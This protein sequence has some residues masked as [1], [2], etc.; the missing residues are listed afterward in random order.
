VSLPASSALTDLTGRGATVA[1]AG[2]MAVV[3]AIDLGDG[4][5]GPI[6][7]I[8]FV[9]V[10]VAVA[11]AVHRRYL[12]TAAVL[13]PVLLLSTFLAVALVAP[14]AVQ[15]P[16]MAPDI[17]WAGRAIAGVVDRGITLTVGY[18]LA[19]ATIALRVASRPL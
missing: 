18:G 13:P 14:H 7:S 6:V 17:S 8:G 4:Q 12:L 2:A 1:S 5:L 19:L 16:G 9:G 11:L 15:V 3:G 10:S